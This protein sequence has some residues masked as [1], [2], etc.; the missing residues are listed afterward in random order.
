MM[1][2]LGAAEVAIGVV[3]ATAA[4][5]SRAEA[6]AVA[7]SR[8]EALEV[9]RSQ[10]EAVAMAMAATGIVGAMVRR[11]SARLRSARRRQGLIITAAAAT[12][13]TAT[14]FATK[15]SLP[16]DNALEDNCPGPN[17]LP[18]A[19][20]VNWGRTLLTARQSGLISF[21]ARRRQPKFTPVF[22]AKNRSV[23]DTSNPRHR[24]V[25]MGCEQTERDA[26]KSMPGSAA[27]AL[28][29]NRAS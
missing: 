19:P 9:A 22:F 10:F 12:T 14:G 17:P 28:R 4:A 5:R 23:F 6:T 25:C 20:V 24:P 8:F 27:S 18:T 16:R 21:V 7:L 1:P 29:I 2:R 11:P 26:T 15:A 3:V 13:P